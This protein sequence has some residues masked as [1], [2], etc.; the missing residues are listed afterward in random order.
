GSDPVSGTFV[1]LASG[2][3]LMVNG[4]LFEIFYDG[5]DG[6]DVTLTRI[7]SA[8]PPSVVY[9]DDSWAGTSN[10]TDADG[11][12]GALGDGSA[13]GYDEFADIPSALAAVAAGGQVKIYDGSYLVTNLA[14]SKS[15]SIQGQSE[16]GVVV[17]PGSSDDHTDSSF[18]GVANNAFVIGHDNVS[19]SNL[20]ID[21]GAGQNFRDAVITDFGSGDFGNI[22]LDHLA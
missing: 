10:G 6:N 3:T 11:A 15:V 7:P 17:S 4:E 14:V 19:I 5:G 9:V 16:A 18:G 8:P 2:A 21:G 12:G 22:Q 20:T 13:F 1:G